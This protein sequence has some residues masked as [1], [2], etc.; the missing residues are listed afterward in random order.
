MEVE[1]LFVVIRRQKIINEEVKEKILDLESPSI[2]TNIR[3]AI[4]LCEENYLIL[5]LN[6]MMER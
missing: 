4:R 5:R 1:L 3:A 2:T 6:N